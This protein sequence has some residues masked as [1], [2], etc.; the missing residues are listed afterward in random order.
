MNT[1]PIAVVVLPPSTP[2]ASF[3]RR[4]QKTC[5]ADVLALKED[6][7]RSDRAWEAKMARKAG[8][9]YCSP[10]GTAEIICPDGQRFFIAHEAVDT[11]SPP[12]SLAGTFLALDV[13][14]VP[15]LVSALGRAAR[16]CHKSF[17]EG[18]R[19][20]VMEGTPHASL[21]KRRCVA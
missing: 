9:L 15:F 14:I 18:V 16:A 3:H 5:E 8:A 7:R 11:Y 20:L 1:A 6:A 12:L 4:T 2:N 17:S 21:N 19:A 13:Y 10:L